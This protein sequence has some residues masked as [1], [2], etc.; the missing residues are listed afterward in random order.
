MGT[1]QIAVGAG[2]QKYLEGRKIF[3]SLRGE[4]IKAARLAVNSD[5]VVEPYTG[6]YAGHALCTMG[7]FTYSMS[8]VVPGMEIGRYTSIG[9]GLIIPGTRH[10]HEWVT[11]SNI[12]YARGG[13]IIDAY[14][15]DN[16]GGLSPR[17]ISEFQ[18]R[19]PVIGNDVWIAQNVTI[20]KG[21][22][23]GDGAVVASNS[24][25]TKDVPP[26]TIV[27][28]N[29]ARLIKARFR[30]DLVESLLELR[31]WEYEAK[32]FAHLDVTDPDIFV[33]EFDR[34]RADLKKFRPGA[35]TGAELVAGNAAGS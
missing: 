22:T 32:D 10:P 5:D 11:T 18:R 27:G 6:F 7:S 25:V 3:M 20:N 15:A 9:K 33:K 30:P 29:P 21:V 16:P 17:S 12:G 8:R 19:L 24:I 31:W 28:G 35:Y 1:L 26:Y 34:L 4:P 2:T 23:I 13:A 14:L